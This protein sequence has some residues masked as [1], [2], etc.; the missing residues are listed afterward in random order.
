MLSSND[1]QSGAMWLLAGLIVLVFAGVFLS[2]LA[3]KRFS[4]S[5]GRKSAAI[6]YQEDGQRLESLRTRVAEARADWESRCVPLLGQDDAL[7]RLR[8]EAGRLAGR[9]DRLRERRELLETGI[10]EAEEAFR[11]Y[12]SRYRAQ[13]WAEATGEEI[14]EFHAPGGKIYKNAV[15]RRVSATGLEIRHE[16]GNSRFLPSELDETWNERFQWDEAEMEAHLKAENERDR[17]HHEAG[18]RKKP[19]PAP[20]VAAKPRKA[21]RREQPRPEEAERQRIEM[22]RQAVIEARER[23]SQ[24]ESEVMR[25]RAEARSSKGRSVPGSLETWEQRAARLEASSIK[26]RAQYFSARGKLAA[27]APGDALLR[28]QDQ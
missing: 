18:R 22:L 7:E 9:A 20:E 14:A 25:A 8:A 1:E 4:F 17:R 19:R 21:P 26:L 2:L 27:I 15:I 6:Q 11:T 28:I 16:E 12:R 3:D 5:N 23:L 10:E 13:V 24:V